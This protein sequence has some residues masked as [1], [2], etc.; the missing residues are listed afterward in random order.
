MCGGREY[1]SFNPD[2]S[3]F[4]CLYMGDVRDLV[5]RTFVL[6]YTYS[7]RVS[8]KSTLSVGILNCRRLPERVFYG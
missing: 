8:N 3:E 7:V 1:P 5:V 6:T 4:V 2:F